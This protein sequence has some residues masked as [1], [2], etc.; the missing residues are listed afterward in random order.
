MGMLKQPGFAELAQAF[1]EATS[2][3]VSN[4]T[5][6]IMDLD[7]TIIA[8]TEK[9]RIGTYHHGARLVAET[10]KPVIIDSENVKD[11]PGAKEGANLPIIDQGKLIGVVGLFGK[12]TEIREAANLLRVYVNQFFRQQSWFREK[13][14]RRELSRR[15]LQLLLAERP[16][17][18]E[19]RDDLLHRLG[20]HL[21]YPLV[22]LG[23][24]WTGENGPAARRNLADQLEEW[25]LPGKGRKQD[26]LYGEVD[27]QLLVLHSL[28]KEEEEALFHPVRAAKGLL[29]QVMHR[30]LLD[31]GCTLVISQL[32]HGP[33]ELPEAR[34]QLETLLERPVKRLQF[35]EDP[36]VRM[37][38][39]LERLES[40][41]G[42]AFARQA[43]E[44][45]KKQVTE[46]QWRQLLETA[47]CYYEEQGAVQRAAERLGIH[48]NTLQYR[49][50][51][52]YEV[53]Q[54]EEATAFEREF[55]IQIILFTSTREEK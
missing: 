5:I 25:L 40:H 17:D 4:R 47:R 14:Y 15:L 43:I 20:I 39:L 13:T 30:A 22:L 46:H 10:G 24:R 42:A 54:L 1:V 3:L 16:E 23:L 36:R 53:L 12:E 48:K 29:Y 2:P 44:R 52:L 34:H 38:Y 11:Y 37:R 45:G 31:K 19:E 21:T 6:N 18:Q 51:R 49:L 8:S 28:K 7:G 9:E 32:C 33:E 55:L 35:V 50:K 41:G 27:Q 26:T